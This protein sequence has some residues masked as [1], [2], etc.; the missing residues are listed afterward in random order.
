M[1]TFMLSK[2]K[3]KK[4]TAFSLEITQAHKTM[5]YLCQISDWIESSFI[6]GTMIRHF[7]IG[8]FHF[9]PSLLSV[10]V[11]DMCSR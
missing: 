7:I 11:A 8:S 5:C 4:K 1:F 10:S 3:K 2:V 9:F 6:V